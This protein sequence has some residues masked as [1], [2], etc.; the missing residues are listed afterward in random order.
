MT[1]KPATGRTN[2]RFLLLVFALFLAVVPFVTLGASST[3]TK[4]LP[5]LHKPA[6]LEQAEVQ[7]HELMQAM[8][9]EERFY[10]VCGD[11]FGVR[12][13]PRLGIPEL[14]FGD[15]SCGLRIAVDPAGKHKT[16][17]FPCTLLLAATWDP[18]I[19][20]EYGKSVAEEFRAD[21]RHFILGPGMN[22]YRNS[23][24]GRNFEFLGED[25]FLAGK[26]VASYVEGAQSVNVGT[27]LKHF[28]GN[29]TED[30][31][32]AANSIIDD[33]TLHEIYMAPFK[34]GIEAGAW[35]VM[36][37]Y[38]LLN[39]EWAG[40]SEFVS[41][42]L[43]RHQLG[44]KYL[45]MT[46]WVSTWHG[47]KL[48]QSG[49]DLEE[50]YGYALKLD[51]D[52]IFGSSNIDRMVVDILKT[53]IASG[54]YELEAKGEFRKPEW[55]NKYP[56]HEQFAK[57]V[58]GE[59]IVLLANNGLLPIES[60]PKWKILVSGNA[61]AQRELSG[62]GS[63]HVVGYDLNT[64]LQSVQRTFGKSNVIYSETPTDDDIKSANLILL[65]AG[66]PGQEGEGSNHPFELP[67]DALIARCTKFNPRTVVNLI[68]GGGA[69]MD[70]ASQAAA[71]VLAFYG[72]QTGPVALLDVLTGK[73]NPSGK[74][75]FTIEKRF[76]DS[77]AAG[78]GELV[79]PGPILSDP[80]E[81]AQRVRPTKRNDFLKNN[82]G[83]EYYTYNLEYKEGIFVGYR[84]YDEKDIEPRFPFGFGLSYT[85]FA[86]SDLNVVAEGNAQSPSAAVRFTITNTGKRVGDE[87]AQ[88]YV[89][90]P[91]TDV[92]QPKKELKGF[93]RVHLASGESKE[94]TIELNPGAFSFWS[95][96]KKAWTIPSGTFKIDVG[97][98]S[99]DIRLA[100]DLNL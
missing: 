10:F 58:N 94:V 22:L 26:I 90:Y 38:N 99:R 63:G 46:D 42:E 39:G 51:R 23:E 9:P 40:E 81:L 78:D 67:D 77:C 16:T 59:G 89:E 66:R 86:Y 82:S 54:I 100:T 84:W 47:D 80:K 18:A 71:I 6:T 2:H 11:G 35:A 5:L 79:K 13:V 61:A 62:G 93:A 72:G 65:F 12:S 56:A 70:W 30:Y 34:A 3:V 52:K 48:A 8:I 31:R 45:I 97:A 74:L 55:L 88:I 37:S 53:G 29:E 7:A 57:Q 25:P 92:P 4:Y 83:D 68:C 33:R 76:E 36:T 69:Q 14:R 17:A 24:D 19:A 28:I 96:A 1:S 32:R 49:T 43:L 98:F 91:Q 50:P 15:A 75:P 41:T 87:I 60:T 27:T 21:G 64:Y 85:K 44:F 20:Q 95:P 73:T